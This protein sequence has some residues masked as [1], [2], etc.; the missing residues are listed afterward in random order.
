MLIEYVLMTE[1]L[2]SGREVSPPAPG[3]SWMDWSHVWGTEMHLKKALERLNLEY[4]C[5]SDD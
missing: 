4:P 1:H 5:D 3:S 2:P